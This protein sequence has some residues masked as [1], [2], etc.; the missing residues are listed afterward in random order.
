[1]S[2]GNVLINYALDRVIKCAGGYRKY[3]LFTEVLHFQMKGKMLFLRMFFQNCI[4][5]RVFM[6]R[7]CT[8]VKLTI[9]TS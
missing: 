9:V 8:K 3:R 4:S 1:M 5:S 7:H 6:V 2:A